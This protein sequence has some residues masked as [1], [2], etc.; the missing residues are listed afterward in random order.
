M[1]K[2]L[3]VLVLCGAAKVAHA[4]EPVSVVP[5]L[6]E[7]T[8]TL[9]Q[10]TISVSSGTVTTISA[11]SGYRSVHISNFAN[12]GTTL[13]YRIDGSTASIPTVGF[14]IAPSA[15]DHPIETNGVI[16]LQLAAGSGSATVTVPI[17]TIRK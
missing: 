14:P 16:S 13:Y 9:S 3:F 4:V 10:S 11:V 6:P 1:K 5:W 15:Q 12:S 8:Y 17:K 7:S 2:F